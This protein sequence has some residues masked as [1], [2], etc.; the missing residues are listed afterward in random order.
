MYIAING[1][2]YDVSANRQTYGP[3]GSYQYF[4][5][6]DAARSFVTGCFA[7]DQTADMRGVEEM[8]LPLDDPQV[9]SHWSASEL[10]EMKER[11]LE[12]A[13]KRVHDG[14]KHWVGFFENSGKYQKVGYVK[15]DK[16]WLDKE[17]LKPLCEQAA[18][19]RRK[20]AI[21]A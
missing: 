18:K 1:T 12:S 9:D 3:G 14:L 17:P 13:R 11:E 20:R 19:N 4:A 16:N 15:R 21:P 2:I 5:G 8:F 10:A 7:T 6:T